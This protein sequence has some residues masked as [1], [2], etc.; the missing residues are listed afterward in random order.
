MGTRLGQIMYKEDIAL[1]NNHMQGY[2]PLLV[3]R[4][5]EMKTTM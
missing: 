2:L 4:E 1:E 5:I 3:S